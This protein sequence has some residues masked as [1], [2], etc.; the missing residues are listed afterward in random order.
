MQPVN[1]LRF[2]QPLQIEWNVHHISSIFL[3]EKNQSLFSYGT[4][5]FLSNSLTSLSTCCKSESIPSVSI[6]FVT[7]VLICFL[8]SWASVY[9]LSV[10]VNFLHFLWWAA[11]LSRFNIWKNCSWVKFSPISLLCNGSVQFFY[12]K[13]MKW[14]FF[15]LRVCFYIKVELTQVL[16]IQIEQQGDGFLQYSRF[17]LF[18]TW[19]LNYNW[20]QE[21]FSI[22]VS[23]I[24]VNKFKIC[25]EFFWEGNRESAIIF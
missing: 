25:Y 19:Y 12:V 11:R 5:H 13:E 10:P 8:A 18:R 23:F 9:A 14:S 20:A 2:A 15:S 22:F 6:H 17:A 16:I 4:T 1:P 24:W 3:K 7:H 21:N